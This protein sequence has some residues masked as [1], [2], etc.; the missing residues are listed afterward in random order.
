MYLWRWMSYGGGL[1]GADDDLIKV[2]TG[3]E[4]KEKIT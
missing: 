1:G 4:S 2:M 3:E